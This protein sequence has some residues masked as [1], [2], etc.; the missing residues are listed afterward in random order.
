M[1]TTKIV[2]LVQTVAEVKALQSSAVALGGT[3]Q[4][5]INTLSHDKNRNLY[6]EN[7]TY[8]YDCRV[9]SIGRKWANLTSPHD[10]SEK[11]G[12]VLAGTVSEWEVTIEAP[13]FMSLKETC[14]QRVSAEIEKACK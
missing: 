3:C 14:S 10:H 2:R 13:G 6:G 8:E 1:N 12:R 4:V 9:A 11:W 7:L 5:T